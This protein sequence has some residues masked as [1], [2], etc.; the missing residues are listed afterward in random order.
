MAGAGAIRAGGAYVEA[1]LDDSKLVRGLNAAK[2]KLQ[3]FGAGI[4][5]I[6]T[7]IGG[8]GAAIEAPLTLAGHS[9][10]EAGTALLFMSQGTN[11]TVE[12][13]YALTRAGKQFGTTAEEIE[14]GLLHM[15]K[16][17]DEAARS[18]TTAHTSL[19]RLNLTLQDLNGMTPDQQLERISQA[20]AAMTDQ[21]HAS[22]L[23]LDIF[24]RRQ[25]GMVR[26][27]MQ[28]SQAI[29]AARAQGGPWTQAS[30]EMALK[31]SKAF[32][33]AKNSLKKIWIAVG[34]A[35]A[36]AMMRMS[37]LVTSVTN[38]IGKWIA[39]NQG[40]VVLLDYLGI[41]LVLAGAAVF[42][43]GKAFSFLGMILGGIGKVFSLIV[44]IITIVISTAV[45]AVVALFSPIG[46]I[47]A[48]VGGMLY[49]FAQSAQGSRALAGWRTG[50]AGIAQAATGAWAGIQ[51]ALAAND[52]M[53]ALEIAGLGLLEIWEH[54]VEMLKTTW[55][56]FTDWVADSPIG[57][58]FQTLR[59]GWNAIFRESGAP[60]GPGGPAAAA[61]V[62]VDL[63]G[64]IEGLAGAVA[65]NAVGGVG[66]VARGAF[67]PEQIA[68]NAAR[69][70]AEAAANRTLDVSTFVH[71]GGIFGQHRIES[72]PGPGTRMTPEDRERNFQALVEQNMAEWRRN[73]V[74]NQ[75][76]GAFIGPQEATP[77]ERARQR[78]EDAQQQ[79]EARRAR[80]AEDREFMDAFHHWNDLQ[81]RKLP[82]LED[83]NETQRKTDVAG[84][85]GGQFAAMLGAT[86]LQAQANEFL[87]RIAANTDGV[88]PVT[89]S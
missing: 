43:L 8:L 3:A 18:G 4:S 82:N 52:L 42:G 77:A 32:E 63:L 26:L 7:M 45:S 78:R 73:Q 68:E 17:I 30:A 21:T 2:A 64:Q 29:R 60:G 59:T 20:L 34:A 84:T 57:E 67:T 76:P 9:F 72:G 87:A 89:V 22:V 11:T 38:S 56:E 71:D 27:A 83:L 19:G 13:F 40:L 44:S 65:A 62:N 48:A 24:G 36:P 51:R 28:G 69:A 58:F 80:E 54:I 75:A 53:G 23:A 79:Q 6:G 86:S 16:A 74:E 10:A 61:P 88:G 39:K 70:A 49:L 25:I 85:F 5:G 14:K 46:L 35:V 66:A 50:F 33:A 12:S 37:Q 15:N 47:V 41:I 81:D 55:K 31:A 1:Y